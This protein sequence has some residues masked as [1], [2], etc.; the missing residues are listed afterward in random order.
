MSNYIGHDGSDDGLDRRGFLRCMAWAGT[1]LLWNVSAGVPASMRLGPG[2]IHTPAADGLFFAQ[3]SDSHIGFSKA[4]N[5]DVTATLRTAVDRLNALPRQPAFVLHTGD[6]T[7]LSKPDEFDTAEQVLRE[8]KTD[9]L[10]YVPGEHDVATDNGGLYLKRFARQGARGQG[11][12]GWYSFDHSGV[13]FVALVN[14]LGIG[15]GGL[16]ALGAEQLDWLRKDLA[17]LAGS[18]PVVVFAH[19]PLWSV[20]PA[21][22]WGTEDSEQ[23]LALLRRFGSVTV[24][25]GHIHQ[26]MQ[27]VEGN[28]AFHTALSTAFPQ[29]APGT[30]PA[31]GP[32]TVGPGQLG[33]FLGVRQVTFVPGQGMLATVDQTLSGEPLGDFAVGRG[34]PS[35]SG[36]RQLH[37]AANEIG[38]ANFAFT[39]QRLTVRAGMTVTWVNRDDTAHALASATG[40]FQASKP[41]D[42]D[43]R[44]SVTFDKPGSYDYFCSIHPV[45]KGRVVVQG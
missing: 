2:E 29:P 31:P 3:I 5:A 15:A 32:M 40:A 11:A 16:G 21:W 43:Q 7:Q 4:A 14:V 38:I 30:A 45:M 13:H 41:L 35:G 44:Y 1:G 17:P 28:V 8:V 26:I 12:G 39:P 19:V 24:L 20:Y 27:K 33:R 42:T 18:T 22:G 25:N 23:A 34:Q 36:G 37:L 10:F 9:R 6:I